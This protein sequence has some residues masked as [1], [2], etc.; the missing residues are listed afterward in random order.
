MDEQNIPQ[1]GQQA[2]EAKEAFGAGEVARRKGR[3]RLL[4]GG[5]AAAPV[6]LSLAS[7]PAMATN[8]PCAHHKSGWASAGS[9]TKISNSD[10]TTHT[11]GCTPSYWR[12]CAQSS[13]PSG[14]YKSYTKFSDCLG[15]TPDV[16]ADTLYAALGCGDELVQHFAASFLN[17]RKGLY[18]SNT[19]MN[20]TNIKSWWATCK[21]NSSSTIPTEGRLWKSTTQVKSTTITDTGDSRYGGFLNLMKTITTRTS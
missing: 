11:N 18:G 9:R 17:C 2:P 10:H 20:E 16:C 15:S 8:M 3:R 5:A 7:K 21:V 13:W 14:C 12:N 6:L 1:S 4:K 19:I